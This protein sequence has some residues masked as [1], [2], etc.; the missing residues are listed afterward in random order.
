M[1][2][3]AIAAA[4]LLAAA[5]A[6]GAA[7]RPAGKAA[8]GIRKR[9]WGKTAAGT[10]VDLYVLTNR[11]GVVAKITN[12]GGILTELHVPD[13]RGKMDDVV[14]GFDNL[15]QYLDGSPYFGATVGR[16]ANR[17]A[18]GRFKLNGKTYKLAVNNPPNHLHGGDRG[19][20]KVVW[21]AKPVSS[22]EGPALQLTY[23]SPDGDEG[24][25]GTLN[26][27]VTYTL[28]NRNEVKIDYVATTN[29][30]T[31]VNL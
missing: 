26:T 10:P 24:Y 25:P 6:V 1:R 11:N 2:R 28:T 21:K 4:V 30:P 22:S 23:R 27:T 31:P 19:F 17:I 12:Y 7:A 5:C 14:L 8:G 13:R 9:A 29:K 16:Y 20:D 3:T 15:Q 18:R